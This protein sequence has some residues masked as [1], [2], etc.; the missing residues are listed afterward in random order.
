MLQ[1]PAT[2]PQRWH[3]SSKLLATSHSLHVQLGLA[4]FTPASHVRAR[5]RVWLGHLLWGDWL[6]VSHHSTLSLCV[7][8]ITLM[9]AA[10][11]GFKRLKNIDYLF[12]IKRYLI[13]N[14]LLKGLNIFLARTYKVQYLHIKVIKSSGKLSGKFLSII[15]PDMPHV[16]VIC[17]P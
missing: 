3:C 15:F 6:E 4:G 5:E 16:K 7:Q 11:G 8:Y 9:T 10:P 1:W 12:S 17:V 2:Q 13:L 14:F